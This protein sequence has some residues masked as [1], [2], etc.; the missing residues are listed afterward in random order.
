MASIQA[1]H[2]GRLPTDSELTQKQSELLDGAIGGALE[3]LA[4]VPGALET[5]PTPVIP[6][7]PAAAAR[8][9]P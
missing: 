5:A 7:I 3:A 9:A 2:G 4:Q 8:I 1:A 6:Q